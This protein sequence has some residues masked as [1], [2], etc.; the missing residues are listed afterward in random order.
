MEESTPV[1]LLPFPYTLED[2]RTALEVF[3]FM[4]DKPI[5]LARL[6]DLLDWQEHWPEES[7][8]TA[9]EH[10]TQELEHPRSGITCVKVA[11]G[12]QLRTKV[13]LAHLAKRWVRVQPHKLSAGCMETL[14]MCAYKQPIMKEDIDV[15]RGVDS[16][17]FIRQL[18]EKKLIGIQGRS[19]LPG[20]P[21]LYETTT[22]FL[23][24]FGLHSLSDLPPLQEL[25]SMIPSSET[26]EPHVKKLRSMVGDMQMD[27]QN[28]VLAFDQ[29]EDE[30][31]L[32]EI[33]ERVRSIQTT[34]ET[35][36]T[37]DNP[38]PEEIEESP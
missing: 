32:Q 36:E 13:H 31:S 11:G 23:E 6:K 15:I 37:L 20:R 8:L 27:P 19:E 26:E 3:L 18:L 30:R 34:V 35:L 5:S 38:P 14:A 28:T 24:V 4:A 10:Y 12:Y 7:L 25:E 21:L 1:E 29:A 33:R 17:H 2:L 22:T 9:L 16:S